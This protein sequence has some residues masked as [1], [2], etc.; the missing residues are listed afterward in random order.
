MSRALACKS[1]VYSYELMR[2]LFGRRTAALRRGLACEASLC[3]AQ[4][5]IVGR[6]NRLGSVSRE[7][8][9]SSRSRQRARNSGRP[10]HTSLPV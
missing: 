7:Q 6:V 1:T 4:F 2:R 5:H 9:F 8:I 3:N 10:R